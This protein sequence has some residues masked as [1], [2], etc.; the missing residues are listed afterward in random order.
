MIRDFRIKFGMPIREYPSLEW[1]T[2]QGWERH[3]KYM[4]EEITEI[5]DDLNIGPEEDRMIGVLD[6]FCDLLVFFE[7]ALF[8]SGLIDIF[9]AGYR[10]V[11]ESNLSKGCSGRSSHFDENGKLK[12]GPGFV[13]PDLRRLTGGAVIATI[14]GPISEHETA[15]FFKLVLGNCPVGV[16]VGSPSM[17]GNRGESWPHRKGYHSETI[18]QIEQDPSPTLQDRMRFMAWVMKKSGAWIFDDGEDEIR[19]NLGIS[20]IALP[21]LMIPLDQPI[22]EVSAEAMRARIIA[23][24]NENDRLRGVSQEAS[25]GWSDDNQKPITE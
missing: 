25:P 4:R 3:L 21:K 19:M 2:T 7:H 12:K 24:E 11:N 13:R 17:S 5:E 18:I 23:L 10:M 1:T 14:R 6:G 20:P 8:D 15:E 9:E 16:N 22:G